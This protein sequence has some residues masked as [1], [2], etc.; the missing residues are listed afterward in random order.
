MAEIDKEVRA[1]LYSFENS[2]LERLTESLETHILYANALNSINGGYSSVVA[3]EADDDYVR[4][5]TEVGEQ[6]MGDGSSYS[7]KNEAKI[8]RKVL[9]AKALTLKEKMAKIDWGN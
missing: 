2:E 3:Y 8:S 6:D 5:A 7:N 9:T 4:L 1:E